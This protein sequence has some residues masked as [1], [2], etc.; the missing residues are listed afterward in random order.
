MQYEDAFRDWGV[1]VTRIESALLNT[2]LG[3]SGQFG[4]RGGIQIR[5]RQRT[6]MLA[7]RLYEGVELGEEAQTP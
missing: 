5:L 2:A 7:Q 6:M 3:A 4:V 1:T